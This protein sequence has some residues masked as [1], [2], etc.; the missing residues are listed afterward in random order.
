M[1]DRAILEA[2]LSHVNLLLKEIPDSLWFETMGLQSRARE[3]QE[4]LAQ[5]DSQQPGSP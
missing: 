1:S 2:E 5:L 4:Q 3:L